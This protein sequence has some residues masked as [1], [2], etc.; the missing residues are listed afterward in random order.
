MDNETIDAESPFKR[1]NAKLRG[2]CARS[3]FNWLIRE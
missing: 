2:D 3:E 1:P